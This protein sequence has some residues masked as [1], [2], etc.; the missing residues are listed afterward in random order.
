M[1]ENVDVF[2]KRKDDA[3]LGHHISFPVATPG[4][5]AYTGK[6]G[7]FEVCMPNVKQ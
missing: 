1:T 7:L 6:S 3:A 2:C 4:V 5:K